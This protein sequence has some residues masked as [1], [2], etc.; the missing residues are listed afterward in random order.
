VRKL[1][2]GLNY[3]LPIIILVAA[4]TIAALIVG[5]D[6][7]KKSKSQ[8]SVSQAMPCGPYRS[9][10]RVLINHETIN[11]EIPNSSAAYAKGL[12]GRPCILPNQAMLFVYS[13]PGQYRFWMKGMK[14]PIDILWISSD[15]KV[16]GQ[17]VDVEPSTYYSKFP[18]FENDPQ[19][20]AQYVLELK[21]DRSREL[22]VNLG[23]T[24]SF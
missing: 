15:H 21:K 24:V 17:E 6:E 10:R 9:D 13:K 11:A 7:T 16:V 22:L 12:G 3:T 8:S 14:F 1:P 20:L 2:K 19:H 23:T 5:S 4:I 18:F